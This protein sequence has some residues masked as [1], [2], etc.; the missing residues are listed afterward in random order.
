MTA[1]DRKKPAAQLVSNMH[2]Q[3]ISTTSTTN[4]FNYTYQILNAT[5]ASNLKLMSNK[6]IQQIQ[7][8]STCFNYYY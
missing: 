3:S 4:E 7:Q 6:L 1:N 2:Y 5:S 8:T